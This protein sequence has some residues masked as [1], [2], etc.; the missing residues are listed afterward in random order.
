M[1]NNKE[2]LISLHK[3]QQETTE[4]IRLEN[5]GRWN[6][7]GGNERLDY[8]TWGEIFSFYLGSPSGETVDEIDAEKIE[9]VITTLDMAGRNGDLPWTELHAFVLRLEYM[10]R[11]EGNHLPQSERAKHVSRKFKRP[12]AKRTY[13]YHLFRAKKAVFALVPDI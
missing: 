3:K 6:R 8:T 13:R 9:L 10:E 7:A 11:S 1:H 2:A 12:C 5:W 4:N